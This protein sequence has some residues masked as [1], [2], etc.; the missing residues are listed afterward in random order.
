MRAAIACSAAPRCLDRKRLGRATSPGQPAHPRR[1]HRPA[2][3]RRRGARAYELDVEARLRRESPDLLVSY[4]PATAA[5][6]SL[7]N[8][9][10]TLSGPHPG[11]EP[12]EHRQD[13]LAEHPRAAG[14]HRGRPRRLRGHRP[15][16]SEVSGATH[17]YLRQSH[18]GLPLYNGQLQ[19]R[20]RPT[21]PRPDRQ[22]RLPARPGARRQRDQARRSAPPTRC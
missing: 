2:A 4:D 11:A 8:P 18:A 22:Q 16:P 12:L 5:V 21:G 6:R 7:S 9:A 19:V 10:G 13:F 15:R 17:L 20:H 3:R 14:A 1:A